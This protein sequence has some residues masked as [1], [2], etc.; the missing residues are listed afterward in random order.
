MNCTVVNGACI[1]ARFVFLDKED[2]I[3]DERLLEL[4]ELEVHDSSIKYEYPGGI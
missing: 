1:Q 3:D 2:R 4:V